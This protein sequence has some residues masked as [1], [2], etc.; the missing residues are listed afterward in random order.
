MTAVRICSCAFIT[1]FTHGGASGFWSKTIIYA[2]APDKQTAL[3]SLREFFERKF[4]KHQH[5][6]LDK[7]VS[8]HALKMI[9]DNGEFIPIGL[10]NLKMEEQ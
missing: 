5:F 3:N 8:P 2:L 6:M 4:K 10:C 9:N 1:T 7:Q